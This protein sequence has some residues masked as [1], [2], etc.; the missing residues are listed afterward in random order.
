MR[1]LLHAAALKCCCSRCSQK[2]CLSGKHQIRASSG[3]AFIQANSYISE[4][5]VNVFQSNTEYPAF[6]A[7]TLVIEKSIWSLHWTILL[8]WGQKQ[9][10]CVVWFIIQSLSGKSESIWAAD[11]LLARC[12]WKWHVY[13]ATAN[14]AF[15]ACSKSVCAFLYVAVAKCTEVSA[16][17]PDHV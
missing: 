16:D 9:D 2:R 3:A 13:T 1:S 10:C 11:A 14:S 4:Q 8:S 12:S 17:S 5:D 15:T 6:A 7:A